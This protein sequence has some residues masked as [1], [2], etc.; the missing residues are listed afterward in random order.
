M[1]DS[2]DFFNLTP[3]RFVIIFLMLLALA[4]APGILS[5][6]AMPTGEKLEKIILEMDSV[7][8]QAYNDCDLSTMMSFVDDDVEF[9]HDKG[10]LL[11]SRESLTTV[12][13]NG[14]CRSANNE[15]ERRPVA[16]SIQVFPMAGIGAVLR[17]QH[18]FH[19]IANP[20]DNGIAY[21]FHLWAFRDGDWKMTRVF[22]YDHAPYSGG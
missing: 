22:S 17:G 4:A 1:P 11:D 10:G 20:N 3:V 15:I 9:Y 13:K 14:L 5:A 12:M 7:F 18:T 2:T 21:F 6:Q 19:G 8:W 16:G